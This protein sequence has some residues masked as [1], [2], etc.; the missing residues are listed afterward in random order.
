MKKL[1]FVMGAT[2]TGKSYHIQKHFC[3]Q[4]VEILDI[5]TY[6]QKAYDEAGFGEGAFLPFAENFQ[7]LKRANEMHAQD[8]IKYLQAGR[9][10]VAEQTF[11]KA[12]RRVAYIDAI[13][14]QVPDVYISIYVMLPPE[15]DE[16][17]NEYIKLKRISKSLQGCKA[18]AEEIE[19]PN[20]AEGFDAIYEVVDGEPILRMD[21]A[22]P[23]IVEEA[24]KALATENE[25]LEQMAE[26][27]KQ[28]KELLES[29]KIRPFWHYCEVCGA[30]AYITAEEAFKEGWDYPPKLGTFRLLGPRKC[31]HCGIE[32]TLY[33]K[34]H[35]QQSL[36]IVLESTLTP[37][38][39]E[40]WRRIRT[41][42]ESLLPEEE[43]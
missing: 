2:A 28:Y 42:P 16:K 7:C 15:D 3:G 14:A 13:R 12:K 8:I 32:K 43:N 29:M 30:K 21:P 25:M 4:N 11:Y 17:W 26:G 27:R 18:E 5:Y 34:V 10:V 39:K 19:F 9:D 31:G 40:T 38:E 36:P 33:W 37:A 1:T 41:E 20:P 23:E 22:Q 6:Q 35:T 24:R